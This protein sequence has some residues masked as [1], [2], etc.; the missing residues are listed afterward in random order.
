MGDRVTSKSGFFGSEASGTD[1]SRGGKGPGKVGRYLGSEGL[2]NR[3]GRWNVAPLWQG[4]CLAH[5][6]VPHTGLSAQ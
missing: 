1:V 5:G 4:L 6:R 3:L 2:Q